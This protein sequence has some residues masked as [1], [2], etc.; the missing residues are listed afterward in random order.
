M[1]AQNTKRKRIDP[2][3]TSAIFNLT[4]IVVISYKISWQI[5]YDLEISTRRNVD[6]EINKFIFIV[7]SYF[8]HVQL[9]ANIK[10]S[11]YSKYSKQFFDGKTQKSD[12]WKYCFKILI[13]WNLKKWLYFLFK[14]ELVSKQKCEL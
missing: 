1:F 3:I 12:D 2:E 9:D 11:Q 10:Y 5:F 8:D 6:P 14:T 13:T 4:H 7:N